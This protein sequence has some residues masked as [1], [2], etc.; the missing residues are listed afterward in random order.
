MS[1]HYQKWYMAKLCTLG[2]Q[3]CTALGYNKGLLIIIV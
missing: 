3:Q 2:Q 1:K